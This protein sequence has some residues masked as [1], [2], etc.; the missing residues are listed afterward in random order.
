MI[1][2]GG[3]RVFG[4]GDFVFYSDGG[5]YNPAINSWMS[6]TTNNAP[7]G[8]SGHTVVWTGTEMIVW[9]GGGQSG[10]YGLGTGGRYNPAANL[11]TN[12]STGGAAPSARSLHTAVWTGSEMIIWGGYNLLF[13][14]PN[15]GGRYNPSTDTWTATPTSGAPSARTQHTAV[16][17]GTEMIIW[18]GYAGGYTN[19]GARYNPVSNTWTP[20]TLFTAPAGR[21]LHTAVWTGKEMIVWGGEN[22][23][24]GLNNGGRYDPVADRWQDVNSGTPPGVRQYHTAVWTGK[25]MII[26]GGTDNSYT[27]GFY[28]GGLYDP[29]S[30]AW[31]PMATEA[32]APARVLHSVV[33]TGTEMLVW[34]GVTGDY[35][36]DTYSYKPP[37][38][39]YLY[40]KP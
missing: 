38:L 19:T 25:E 10:F 29:V 7:E 36:D 20:T 34:G 21:Q 1:I 27:A 13:T 12:V 15:S 18:G 17:T 37:R 16:W 31:M 28:Y 40:V 24:G 30:D 23:G 39:M 35:F 22:S 9:G 2:W 33:W 26:W 32:A 8:R 5:R 6:M 11:W 3:E 14:I 4:V